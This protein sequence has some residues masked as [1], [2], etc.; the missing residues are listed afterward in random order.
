[1]TV[2]AK[3]GEIPEGAMKRVA[4]FDDYALL[5]NVEGK[6]YATQDSCG[7]QRASLARGSLEGNVVTCALHG[8]KFDLTTGRN[9]SGLHL[10][11]PPEL[12]QK[13]P[14]EM[15]AMFKKT[16]EIVAA[17]EIKPLKTYKVEIRGDSVYIEDGA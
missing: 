17:V 5:S 4:A 11:M 15:V 12:M 14:P 3:I 9:V 16:S 1:M 6:I 10:S 8:A 13:L 2:V 7:H